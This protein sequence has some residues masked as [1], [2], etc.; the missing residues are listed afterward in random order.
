MT[1]E[2]AKDV[3]AKWLFGQP[4]STVI[5]FAIL[6]ALFYG[7]NTYLPVVLDRFDHHIMSER[8]LFERRLDRL[9]GVFR[10]ESKAQR[11]T[12]SHAIDQFANQQKTFLEQLTNE[13]VLKN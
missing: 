12:F 13:D 11:E 4:A 3:A 7:A 5:L 6:S 2:S 9:E 10:D 8:E 1:T